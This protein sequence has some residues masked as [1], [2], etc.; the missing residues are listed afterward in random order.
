MVSDTLRFAEVQPWWTMSLDPV[1]AP[2]N[3]LFAAA[4]RGREELSPDS[5]GDFLGVCVRQVGVGNH[6]L[7]D[8]SLVVLMLQKCQGSHH[9]EPHQE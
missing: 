2:Q 4:G 9:N 1:P 3:R 6:A 5:Q 8:S 7:F